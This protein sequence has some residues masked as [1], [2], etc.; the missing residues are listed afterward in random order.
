M[1]RKGFDFKVLM[2]IVGFIF[3]AVVLIVTLYRPF[4][5]VSNMRD[6]TITVTD[7]EVKN[8]Y[9]Q[10]GKYLVFG[11]DENGKVQVFEITD[12][13]FKWR[14]D[15]S[16]VYASIEEGKTYVFTVGGS[17]SEFLSWYPNIYEVNE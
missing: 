15:S 7:K 8:G 9:K 2:Y 17:R 10:S 5:K 6:V 13:L 4:N 11:K 16:N 12:S 1:R 14:F 3:M